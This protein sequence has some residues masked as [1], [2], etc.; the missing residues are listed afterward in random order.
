MPGFAILLLAVAMADLNTLFRPAP[1]WSGAD[2]AYSIPL[3]RHRT[4]WLFG[5]TFT[6]PIVNGRRTGLDMV[7]NS[8][9]W[10]DI[11]PTTMQFFTHPGRALL[12]PPKGWFWPSD[13]V[14]VGHHLYLF[15]KRM[16]H[17]GNP[18]PF[19]FAWRDTWLIDVRNPD[20]PPTEW[21]WNGHPM[22]HL[23]GIAVLR[24]GSYLYSVGQQGKDLVL[25]RA[26]LTDLFS[27]A[28]WHD[29]RWVAD[30]TQASNVFPDGATEMSLTR[31]PGRDGVYAVYTQFGIGPEIVYRHA[32]S[33][34]GPWSEPHPLYHCAEQHVL[35]YGAKAHE[36]LAAGPGEL[37]VTYC[38]NLEVFEDNIAHPDV[39]FPRAISLQ[40]PAR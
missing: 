37:V 32:P 35:L 13:G 5:D 10:S 40:I 26:L 19:D 1:G 3:S 18:A 11:P 14:R 27:W 33:I 30:P 20:A 28:W 17:A 22:D 16:E 23:L 6:Q 12:T 9:A 29:G 25:A 21:R 31:V 39:Y 7:N 4:L 36:E 15:M 8:A 2:A 38:R 34:E 24:D